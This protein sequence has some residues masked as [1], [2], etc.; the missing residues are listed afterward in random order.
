MSKAAARVILDI[1]V[2]G[3]AEITR[4]ICDHEDGRWSI[5]TT[6]RDGSDLKVEQTFTFD[7]IRI[8]AEMVLEGSPDAAKRIGLG[9]MLAAGVLTMFVAMGVIQTQQGKR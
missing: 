9:K 7:E 5:V 3:S 4:A 6:K 2:V 1:P 8:W